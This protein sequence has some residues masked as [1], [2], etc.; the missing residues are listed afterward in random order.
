M[1]L[2]S[3]ATLNEIFFVS[4]QLVTRLEQ[5]NQGKIFDVPPKI[6]V[7]EGICEIFRVQCSDAGDKAHDTGDT[8]TG[9]KY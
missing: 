4:F 5:P 7:D 9:M 6:Q 8:S 1:P 2:L 3:S